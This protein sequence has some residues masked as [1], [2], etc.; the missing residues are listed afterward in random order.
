[1]WSF[2]EVTFL[3]KNCKDGELHLTAQD[4]V[5]DDVHL[6]FKLITSF[7]LYNV[8]LDL[9]TPTLEKMNEVYTKTIEKYA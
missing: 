5:L 8:L 2:F 3:Q 9:D 6:S 1:M 7:D 4:K